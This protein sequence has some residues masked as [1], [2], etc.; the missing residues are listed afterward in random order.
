MG[1]FVDSINGMR[2]ACEALNYPV[3]SGMYLYITRQIV[4]L[5]IQHP[6]LVL[7][8]KILDMMTFNFKNTENIIA[9]VGET[10]GH[11][12]Q[13]ALIYDVMGNKWKTWP[14]NLI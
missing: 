3:I 2:E 14:L 8:F 13:S 1:Q 4:L 11:L 12:S 6:Q 10:S 9:V 5:F 7:A